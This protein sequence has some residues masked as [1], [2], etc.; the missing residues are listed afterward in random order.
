MA[1]LFG[2]I[3][4]VTLRGLRGSNGKVD[5]FFPLMTILLKFRSFSSPRRS[6]RW[7]RHVLMVS[8]SGVQAHGDELREEKLVKDT[9]FCLHGKKAL[10][11][12]AGG[13]G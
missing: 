2:I 3:S 1:K 6:V 13:R 12:D 4:S 5:V 11:G 9:T 8:S 10:L 7:N